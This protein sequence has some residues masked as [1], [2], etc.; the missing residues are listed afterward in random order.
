MIKGAL[1]NGHVSN[2]IKKFKIDLAS[3][4][5]VSFH[6]VKREKYHSTDSRENLAVNF[7]KGDTNINERLRQHKIPKSIHIIFKIFHVTWV[8]YPHGSPDVTTTWAPLG[9]YI[10]VYD[11][12]PYISLARSFL[13][14]GGIFRT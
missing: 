6:H 10:L 3:I 4:P 5:H 14:Q 12:F 7:P 2:I 9:I 13:V 8:S 11:N 1:P